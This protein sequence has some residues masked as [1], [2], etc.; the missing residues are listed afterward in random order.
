MRFGVRPSALIRLAL[1]AT[2]SRG[3][4]IFLAAAGEGDYFDFVAALE[5]VLQMLSARDQ[6]A[7]HF[8]RHVRRC[9]LQLS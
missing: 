1:F 4:R 9:E 8:H 2:F 6:R 7:I 5:D 3:R